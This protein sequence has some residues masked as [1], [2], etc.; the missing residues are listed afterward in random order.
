MHP[1]DRVKAELFILGSFCCAFQVTSGRDLWLKLVEIPLSRF[2]CWN[3]LAWNVNLAVILSVAFWAA[4]S[5]GGADIG[6]PPCLRMPV[7]AGRGNGAVKIC[8]VV[9]EWEGEEGLSDLPS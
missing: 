2:P 3:E 6:T 7:R 8:V 5:K 4:C 1:V 9:E